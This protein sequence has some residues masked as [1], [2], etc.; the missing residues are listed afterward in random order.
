MRVAMLGLYP[1]DPEHVLGGVEAVTY[2]LTQALVRLPQMDVHMF[3]LRSDVASP[4]ILERDGVVVHLLPQPRFSRLMWHREGM[5]RLLQEV[6]RWGPD[7]V[8]AHGTDVYAG[9]AVR[10]PFP[11]VITVHGI[12]AR[13]AGTVWGW[14]RRLAR[15]VDRW[16][17]RWV[18]AQAREVIAISPYVRE[19][20]PWLRTRFHFVENPVDPVYFRAPEDRVV[21]GRV[22]CVARVIPRKDILTLI[23][24]FDRVAR[25]H[26]SAQLHIAGEEHS[27][28]EYARACRAEVTARGLGDR[29]RFLGPLDREALLQEYAA[30]QVLALTSVQETAPVVIAEAMAASTPVVATHVGGVPYM[31]REGETGWLVPPED[32]EALA[33][34]LG[35]ALED[36]VRCRE[37]GRRARTE[38]QHRFHPQV[39]AS[40]HRDIYAKILG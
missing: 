6:T 11:H 39:V 10:A 23:R 13:E 40:R 34:A 32:V 5:R 35:Q 25:A 18:L 14:R 9:A 22:L 15:E 37:M 28:P 20:Y 17:E 38:A 24:A 16:F 26:P 12:M 36:P 4:Q 31:V 33:R 8:H 3:T 30:A 27:F 21:A 29:V 1:V 7:V 19:A 2:L